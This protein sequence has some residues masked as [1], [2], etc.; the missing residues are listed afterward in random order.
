MMSPEIKKL[1][2]EL[3][4]YK[5]TLYIV[6]AT[7]IL[8]ALATTQL[9][10]MIKGLFD[11]L[12]ANQQQAMATLVP[13]ALGLALVQATSRYFHIYLMNYTA[14]R[15]VQGLR[16]KLQQKFMRLNLSFHN[17]YAAGSGG[18]IS[19]IL[20]DIRIIQD[21]LRVVADIFLYPLMLVGLLINL[22]RIDWKLTLATFLIAPLIAV[23]LKNIARSMR[24]YIPQ[25]R[26][27][28]EYMTSTIKESLDGVRIIQSFNLEKD[29]GERL[30]KE[31]DKYLGIRKTIYKRQEASGPVTE[32]LATAIVLC[33]FMYVSYEI[34][35][36][37]STP[38]TFVGFVASLLMINQPIKRVQ[39]AY[40]RIQEVT[41]SLRRIFEIIENESEVP[42]VAN[43]VPFP[44]DWKKITYK[45]VSF[46]YGKEMI[47]KNL[48]LEINRGEVVALV[49]A[50]GSGKSTIV[51]L[52]ERFFDPTSGEILIDDVNIHHI[53][54]Q[55]LRRNVALVTQ[56]VF[57]FSDTIEKN[58]WAGDYNRT[59]EDIP[60]MA[61]LANAHDFIMKTPQGYQSRVGDR[62]N[63]L[64]GGEKQRISIARAMFK[65]APVLI[66]D[67]ATSA[68]DTASEIEVQK[69][70]DHLM[71]GRTA[72]VI[73][74][75]LSTI[76]KADKIVVMKSGEIAEIGTHK[77]LMSN[78]GEYFRFHSLQHT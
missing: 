64:S 28:M 22:I 25:E 9:A 41:I 70:I 73:A 21:G 12:S 66:L 30:I 38:G 18:L 8:N 42:Q 62:G 10:Y 19:R 77:D 35:A 39:E 78:E 24:K 15:V 71:E 53:G 47:L 59:R 63:L 74:H 44:K 46:S 11:G 2:G 17:N 7:G 32:F 37:R 50:S 72:L 40:V 60:A 14:E 67:E 58:I 6:A 20:N 52:L 48:N 45:N 26:D 33:V 56:D 31:S 57:L 16:Q 4:Q 55:D 61:K 69:G 68:L 3:K 23:I 51:N 34:A 1:V 65:D 5:S 29:M 75:R 36:G 49:G 76:Q 54:L 43:P 27:V 13:I